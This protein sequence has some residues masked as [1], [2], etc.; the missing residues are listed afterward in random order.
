[1]QELFKRGAKIDDI[2]LTDGCQG[3]TAL[4][5]AAEAGQ[6]DAVRWLLEHGADPNEDTGDANPRGNAQR[7][8][9]EAAKAVELLKAHGAR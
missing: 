3:Y 9:N 1:M 4:F 6:A 5:M 7:R 2:P 8:A